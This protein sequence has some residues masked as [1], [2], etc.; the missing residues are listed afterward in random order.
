VLQS[1]SGLALL[2]AL[3]R[4]HLFCP[5]VDFNPSFVQ[6]GSDG[7]D[8]YIQIQ[9]FLEFSGSISCPRGGFPTKGLSVL[10]WKLGWMPTM[11][12]GEGVTD[13]GI[14]SSDSRVAEMC[15]GSHFVTGVAILEQSKDK[16]AG[17]RCHVCWGW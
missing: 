8:T 17:V 14:E 11:W 2:Q 1:K 15:L 10:G 13:G 4:N 16:L 12:P 3:E 6:C 9:E 7:L 5:T